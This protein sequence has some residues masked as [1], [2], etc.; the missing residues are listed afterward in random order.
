M[1]TTT[2]ADL[3]DFPLDAPIMEMRGK[4]TKLFPVKK[5]EKGGLQN[6]EF[7][8]STGSHKITFVDGACI[9]DDRSARGKEVVI[10]ATNSPGHGWT[11]F[12]LKDGG[13][14]GIQLWVTSSALI[15]FVGQSAGNTNRRPS[16]TRPPANQSGRGQQ[17]QQT[18]STDP[19]RKTNQPFDQYEMADRIVDCYAVIHRLVNEKLG[20]KFRSEDVAT[21]FIEYAKAG[22]VAQ[23]VIGA[24][25]QV[26]IPAAPK[27]PALWSTAIVPAGSMKG[28]ALE[29]LSKEQVKQLFDFYDSKGS[30]TPFAEC[31][32]RAAQE[33]GLLNKTE[34]PAQQKGEQEAEDDIP[35]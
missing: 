32:Y 35:F 10:K 9:D 27:D 6:G 18:G 29:E 13:N 12:K 30:N 2:V 31:V 23:W 7:T 17:P 14:F 24:E 21:V 20:D 26:K 16:E 3:A 25:R 28:K 22:G 4:L 1:P 5:N 34:A 11:G 15:E 8:D 33:L 19:N